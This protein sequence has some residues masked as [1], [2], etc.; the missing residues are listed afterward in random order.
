MSE[1]PNKLIKFWQELKRR[2][3]GK[4]IVAYAATAFILLQ[5]A[6]ILTPALILPAWTTRLITLIL[7]IGFPLAVIFSWIFDITPEGIKKTESIEESEDKEIVR[8]PSKRIF[9]ASNIII[10]ALIIVVAIL[11]YPKIFNRNTL[12]K[13]R[14]SGERISVAVMPFQNMTNDT[15]WN[16]W[17]DG[18]QANLI[19]SLTNSEELKV[20]QTETMNSLLQSKSL[21]NYA[22][23]TPSIASNIS[24]KLDANVFIYGSINQSGSTIRVNAQ[25]VDSKTKDALK[26]F[27]IDG[28]SE[29]ILHIADSLSKMVKNYL[30]ISKMEKG[31]SIDNQKIVSINSPEAYGNYIYGDNAFFKRDYSTA[32][33]F[34]L[35]AITIDSNFTIAIVRLSFAYQ[36][37]GLYD[38]AKQWCLRAYEKRDRMSIQQKNLINFA[39]AALFE[40]PYETIKYLKEALEIDDQVPIVH[41]SLSYCYLLLYEY[42]KAIAED[43]KALQIYKKWDSKPLWVYN[44]TNLGYAYHETGQY[45]KERKLY[46]I[47]E[48]D[49]RDD[50]VLIRRQTILSLTT[51]DTVTANNYIKEYISLRKE[52]SASEADISTG[53][54]GIYSETNI[55][56]KAEEYYREALSLEPENPVGLNNLAYFLI[57]KERNVSEGLEL[58]NKALSLNPDQYEFL[59][60]KGWGLYKQGKYQE[61]LDILQKSWDLR[62]KLAVYDHDAWLHLEAAKRAVA[63]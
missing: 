23:I 51:A 40:T 47:A 60:T 11:A 26:S 16:V 15:T 39:Y 54:A 6:D 42:D 21:A 37:Q 36:Y 32:E 10:A 62:M 45:N 61:A 19:A 12:E 34:Y 9:T 14:S 50:P 49:F 30:V 48:Q 1:T 18:I 7:I 44:Y 52:R 63:N 38:Q 13:L 46:K 31:E 41:H 17:Q 3:T 55:P 33:K 53:L 56:G 20:R 29:N 27:Q 22:A 28:T 24:Q 43:K 8:K 5:L 2:K 58:I 57:D 35:K 25:I 59:D 4:V